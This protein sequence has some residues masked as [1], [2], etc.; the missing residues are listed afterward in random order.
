MRFEVVI[1]RINESWILTI[2]D[3]LQNRKFFYYHWCDSTP[4]KRFTQKFIVDLILGGINELK[5]FKSK[6]DNTVPSEEIILRYA[7]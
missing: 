1:S 4:K 2:Y 3:L 6:L 5:D 7:I